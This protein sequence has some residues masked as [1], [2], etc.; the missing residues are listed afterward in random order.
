[1]TPYEYS[2]EFYNTALSNLVLQII[3]DT[4]SPKQAFFSILE[5]ATRK[6][7]MC[8]FE[9]SVVFEKEVI[10]GTEVYY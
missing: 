10:E 4:F 5:V 1:M 8:A 3:A 6:E 2:K 9:E 7:L